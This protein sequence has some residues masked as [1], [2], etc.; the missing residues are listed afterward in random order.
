MDLNKSKE[1]FNPNKIKKQVHIIGC[2]ALGSSLAE[3]MARQG[4]KNITLYDFDIVESH[5]LVNQM[6]VEDQIKEEKTKALFDLLTAI[7]PELKQTLKIEGKYEKQRLNDYVFL[8]LDSIDLRKEI[9]TNQKYNG[10][11]DTWFDIRMSLTEGQMYSAVWANHSAKTEYLNSFTFTDEEATSEVSACG[12]ELSIAPTVRAITAIT[13]ANF[14]KRI[15]EEKCPEFVVFD[16]YK[17]FYFS[18]K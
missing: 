13:M 14:M 5:N 8:C 18:D 3:L 1:F 15:N 11:I 17:A 6:Y 4:I 16:P 12:F 9:A 7:N 10:Q 2:G